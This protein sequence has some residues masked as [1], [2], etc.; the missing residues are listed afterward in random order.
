[1]KFPVIPEGYLFTR[2]YTSYIFTLLFLL[3]MF[4]YIDRMVISSLFPLRKDEWK[5]T[6]T[7]CRICSVL[8]WPLLQGII[9]NRRWLVFGRFVFL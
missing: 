2:R 3:Y 7:Q 4:D 5:L 9:D 1:M 8:S 6:D